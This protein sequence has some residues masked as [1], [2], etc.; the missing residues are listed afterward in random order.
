MNIAKL[1]LSLLFLAFIINSI[2]E[3]GKGKTIHIIRPGTF[4]LSACLYSFV[5]VILWLWA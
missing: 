4:W 3:A 1:C 2:Y 5:I